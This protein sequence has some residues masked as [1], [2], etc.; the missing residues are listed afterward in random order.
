MGAAG[1]QFAKASGLT[2]IATA[3]SHNFDYVK[4]LG[5]D[6]VFD[7]KSPT[8]AADIKKF[9]NNRLRYAWDCTGKGAGICAA[10]LSDTEPGVYSSIMPGDDELLKKTNPNVEGPYLTLAYDAFGEPYYWE[11]KPVPVKPDEFEF[12]VGFVPL[13]EDLYASGKVR[14]VKISV[15][16]TGEGLEGVL[17]GLDE[18]RAERVSG[19]KLVY[20]L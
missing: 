7:Y 8:C 17:K 4:S 5:A 12:A 1:I 3:S 11:G 18:L 14:P 20:T 6:A 10:A 2:V 9:T 19:T 16:S 15:N 13:A